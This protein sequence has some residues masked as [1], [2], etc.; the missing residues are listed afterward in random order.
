MSNEISFPWQGTTTGDAGAYSDDYFA[1]VQAKLSA[2][3]GTNANYGV[4]RGTLDEYEVV[5]TSPASAQ[6]NVSSGSAL[7][8]GRWSYNDGDQTF[9]I[10]AN[11]SGNPRIDAVILNVDYNNQEVRIE[12]LQGTPAVSPSIPGLTQTPDVQWQIYLAR[13]AVASGFTTIT[14]A[15]ITDMRAWVNLPDGHGVDVTNNSGSVLEKGNVVVLDTPTT[16]VIKVTT[17]TAY[18]IPLFGVIETRTAA[19]GGTGRVLRAGVTPV[20]CD[21]SVSLGDKLYGS[22]S[23]AGQATSTAS[24]DPHNPAF[25]VVISA[26]GGAG[27]PCLAYVDFRLFKA[28]N[29]VGFLA[30]RNGNQVVGGA[31]TVKVQLNA[32]AYDYGGYF[33][34]ATNYRFTP[35][36]AGI[37]LF[38]GA[39]KG[40]GIAGVTPVIYVNGAAVL[41]GTQQTATAESAIVSFIVDMNGTTDYVELYAVVGGAMNITGTT[42]PYTSMLQGILLARR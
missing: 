6:I 37:Y 27:T 26:N 12:V 20:I 8:Q 1:G 40:S 30:Y 14:Q 33:D 19:S 39:V 10:G 42:A 17:A 32:E 21:G 41:A 11:S 18:N 22:A 15:D 36:V 5:A 25:G 31:S 29:P 24:N 4:V 38:I 9:T 7:I 13:I 16:E 3:D 23:S 34:S 35:L 2:Y 28:T